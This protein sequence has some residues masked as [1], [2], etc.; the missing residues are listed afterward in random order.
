MNV[1]GNLVRSCVPPVHWGKTLYQ[2]A[3]KVAILTRQTSAVISPSRPESAETD[4]SPR[5]APFPMLRSQLTENLNI[6][7]PGIELF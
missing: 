6:P 4:S 7:Y 3:E 2:D 1:Y 5:H